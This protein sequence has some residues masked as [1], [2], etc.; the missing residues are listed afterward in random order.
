VRAVDISIKWKTAVPIIVLIALGV[1]VT[2][3]VTGNRTRDIVIEEAKNSTLAQQRDTVLNA[4]TTLML[5]GDYNENK[6]PFLEQMRHI[7]DIR[8]IRSPLLDEQFGR[9]GDAAY[10]ADDVERG[11]IGSGIQNIVIDGESVRGVFPYVAR[12]EFMGKNCL[13]CHETKEGAVLGA[14]SIRVPLTASFARIRELQFFYLALG[15]AGILAALVLVVVVVGYAH[16]PLGRL[17]EQVREV[18][19]K[20]LRLDLGTDGTRDEVMTLKGSIDRMVD[21]FNEAIKKIISSVSEMTSVVDMLRG[22]ADKSSQG[23]ATQSHQAVHIASVA[24]QMTTTI[25]DIARTAAEATGMSETAAETAM[26]GKEVAEASVELI[27]GSVEATGELSVL[28]EKLNNRVG[29]IGDVVTVIKDVADQTNLLALNAAIEAARAGDQG[30]GFAVVADEVRKLAE[31]TIKATGEIS[32]KIE[33]LQA[34]SGNTTASMHA[35]SEKVSGTTEHIERVGGALG[36]IVGDVQAMRDSIVQIAA[37]VEEQSSASREVAQNIEDSADI[38]KEIERLSSVVTKDVGKL[39]AVIENLRSFSAEFHLRETELA[40]LEMSKNDHRGWVKKI[41]AHLAGETML[42]VS[43]IKDHRTCRLG[44]WYY[45]EG[46]DLCGDLPSFRA[47]EDVHG[48]IHAIGREIV[49]EHDSG[50]PEKARALFAEMKG[51][52]EEVIGCLDDISREYE[53]SENPSV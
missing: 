4:L 11:V 10:P 40:I 19:K 6:G 25:G 36:G 38:S 28:I 18:A 14:V 5:V 21:V 44:Q 3:F 46:V 48:R 29:E 1:A 37:A 26:K 27:K 7:G 51:I 34:E 12:A 41:E 9:A 53:A 43:Q 42:D 47:L 52:S 39:T 16:A 45:G 17:T 32:G 22:M 15:A 2:V 20:N 35:A 30:R 50:N 31:R 33:T 8:L 24:E 13:S 23:A 49:L